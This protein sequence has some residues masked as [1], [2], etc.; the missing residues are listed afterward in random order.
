MSSGLGMYRGDDCTRRKRGKKE[1]ITCRTR[2][3]LGHLSLWQQIGHTRTTKR[4]EGHSLVTPL[5]RMNIHEAT[6]AFRK[7]NGPAPYLLREHTQSTHTPT[8]TSTPSNEIKIYA[9]ALAS[10]K[11]N[12]NAN[13][14]ENKAVK[15][16]DQ[17]LT[18]SERKE[19]ERERVSETKSWSTIE[20]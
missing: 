16:C 9:S 8:A 14:K 7:T 18:K 6:L 4:E 19:G 17:Q 5:V 10:D 1:R 2:S 11:V 15:N 20:H 12:V 3:Q 13:V